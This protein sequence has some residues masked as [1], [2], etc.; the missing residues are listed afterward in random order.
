MEERGVS[1]CEQIVL[2]RSFVYEKQI[3]GQKIL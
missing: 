2:K 1:K 3:L